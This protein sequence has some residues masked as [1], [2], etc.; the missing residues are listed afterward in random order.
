[1]K[2]LYRMLTAALV[3]AALAAPAYAGAA[4]AAATSHAVSMRYSGFIEYLLDATTRWS[5]DS[6]RTADAVRGDGTCPGATSASDGTSGPLPASRIGLG[7]SSDDSS[8]FR[9]RRAGS[10]PA[11]PPSAARI[12]VL[13]ILEDRRARADLDDLPRYITATRWLT[14]STTA[15]SCEMKR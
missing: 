3:A 7:T 10:A 15:M 2:P 11:R 8:L 14:R 1:M 9:R 4:R 12:G 13:W 6:V 5:R